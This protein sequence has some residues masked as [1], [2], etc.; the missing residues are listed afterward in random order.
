MDSKQAKGRAHDFLCQSIEITHC[1]KPPGNESLYGF[2]PT[3]DEL[4]TFKLFGHHSIGAGE[5]IAVDR[6][7]GEVRYLGFQGE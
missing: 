7:S 6:E 1:P 4:F 2:D 3:R 5:Y